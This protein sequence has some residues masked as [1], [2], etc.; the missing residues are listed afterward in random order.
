MT[1]LTYFAYIY[2]A[3]PGA[4]LVRFFDVPEA[5]TQGDTF[6]DA[7]ANAA[8]ALA[9]ALEGYIELSLPLP[10]RAKVTPDDAAPGYTIIEIAVDPTIAA[11]GLLV[12][13]MR[14][15]GLNKVA[16]AQR[17]GRDEKVVRRILNGK[18]ASFELTLQALKAVGVR[19]ALAA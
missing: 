13:A 6:E 2:E 11:R 14:A 3:E 17:I 16:L 1:P 18:G 19:P 10:A 12:G 7:K 15:Q 9:A 4:W 5:I 8:D